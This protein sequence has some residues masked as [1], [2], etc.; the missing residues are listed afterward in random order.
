MDDLQIRTAHVS[1]AEGIAKVHVYT[2]Q[3]AYLGLIPDSFLQ[4]LN[5]EK[6][7][8]NWIKNIENPLP[9]SKTLV[10]EIDGGIVGFI[11]IGVDREEDL[12]HQGEVYA[13][14][15]LPGI[16]GRGIGAALMREGLTALKT[17]GLTCAVLWVLDGNLRTRAW[18]ES[19]GWRS[20]G[21]RKLDQRENFALEEIQ[22]RIEF[23]SDH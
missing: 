15:V 22:Y 12:P 20:T 23:E 9:R 2:W 13:I 14:Y 4:G 10:A 19:H 16:Q 21:R 17:E 1:D 18:Y 11:G 6:G 5:V 7:T 3:S 8:V